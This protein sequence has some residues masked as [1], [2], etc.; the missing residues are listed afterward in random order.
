VVL[1]ELLDRLARNQPQGV[2]LVAVVPK[3]WSYGI[4]PRIENLIE[5]NRYKIEAYSDTYDPTEDKAAADRNVDNETDSEVA[6]IRAD[7][8]AGVRITAAF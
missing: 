7:G 6:D 3:H 8:N 1:G 4:T 5:R 2:P